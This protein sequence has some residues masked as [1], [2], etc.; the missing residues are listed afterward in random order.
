[1]AATPL[2]PP[3]TST[4]AAQITTAVALKH[5]L[6]TPALC[7]SFPDHQGPPL[8]TCTTTTSSSLQRRRFSLSHGRRPA[9]TAD[10]AALH[11]HFRLPALLICSLRLVF[12]SGHYP[13]IHGLNPWVQAVF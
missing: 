8:S 12:C 5:H 9:C 1:M 7:H 2:P 3:S 13:G 10:A 4:A 6:A 11:W